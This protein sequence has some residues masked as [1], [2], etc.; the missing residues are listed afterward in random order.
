MTDTCDRMVLV[1]KNALFAASLA[2]PSALFAQATA[3][4]YLSVQFEHDSNVFRVADS[5]VATQFYGGPRLGDTDF[6]YVAGA[7]GTY[8][9]G[10]QKLTAT[11]EGRKIDY[12]HFTFLNHYEY[13]GS[14]QLD[15]KA[16]SLLDGVVQFKQEHLAAYFGDRQSP[17][18]EVDT[19]RNIVGKLNLKI[20]TDWRLETG[21]NFRTYDSPLQFYPDFAEHQ[22]GT[23]LGL[24]YL[25]VAN[26]TYGVG[27]DHISGS[28]T[29]ATGVGPYT[30]TSADLQM[31]YLITGLTSLNGALGYTKRNQGVGED[32]FG[33]VTG[34]FSYKR[35][36]TGKTSMTAQVARNVFS[37]TASAG[38]EIDSTASIAADWQAT[39]RLDVGLKLAYTR[40][41]FV[42]QAIPGSVANGRVDH[43]PQESLNITYQA[44]RNLQIKAY[45]NAQRRSSNVYFDTFNDNTVGIQAL[46]HWR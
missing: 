39:Y 1:L 38:S 25:G 16:A 8:L 33:A 28:F 13:L 17:T 19:D 23:H 5:T 32:S 15:W 12:D 40:S 36:L 20:R 2:F 9:W 29:H 4:P 44:L 3:N 42:G 34:Q 45:A 10:L 26:L 7:D 31:T 27:V 22:T 6:R 18:L 30:Q 14:L 43:S 46:A 24:S 21:I 37:Y 35:Q 11:V 41:T